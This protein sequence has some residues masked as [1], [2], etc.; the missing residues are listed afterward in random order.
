M[1]SIKDVHD[2]EPKLP[3]WSRKSLFVKSKPSEEWHQQIDFT[4]G[5]HRPSEQKF[6]WDLVKRHTDYYIKKKGKITRAEI[7][8]KLAS[9]IEQHEA[10]DV[11]ISA[12]AHAMSPKAVR[13]IL[14][15]ELNVAPTTFF[16]LEM[17][18]QSLIAANHCSPTSVTELEARWARELLPYA[19]HGTSAAG[20]Y[21]EGICAMLRTTDTPNMNALSD[22]SILARRAF[23]TFATQLEGMRLRCQ[24][25]SA[26][27]AAA[28]MTKMAQST[29]AVTPHGN[30]MSEHLMDIQFPVWRIW[31]RW[32]PDTSFIARLE[33]VDAMKKAVLVDMMALEGPDFINGTQKTLK[34]GLIK[35]YTAGKPLVRFRSLVLEVEQGTRE[36]LRDILHKTRALLHRALS[37][38]DGL[39]K[40]F[41][42]LAI[43]KPITREGLQLLEAVGK[44]QDTP[45]FPV[46]NATL[47]IYTA[48]N[49]IGGGHITALKHLICA[50]DDVRGEELR[51]VMLRPWLV[52]GIEKCIK[53][54]QAA[55]RMHINTGITWTHL[56]LEFHAFLSIVKGSQNC[57]LLLDLEIQRQ[58]SALPPLETM[59]TLL[60]IYAA[61]ADEKIKDDSS[62]TDVLKIAIAA[63]FID[64]LLEQGTLSHDLRDIVE[65]IIHVWNETTTKAN[66]NLERRSLAL[67]SSRYAGA[68]FRLRIH[69]FNQI[70][71]LS[72]DC[73]TGLLPLLQKFAEYPELSSMRFTKLLVNANDD[74][75][76]CWKGI[77]HKLICSLKPTAIIDYMLEH[78]KVHQFFDFVLDLKSLF[79]DFAGKSTEEL[80]VILR[81]QLRQWMQEIL[82]F[83]PAMMRLEHALGDYS[84][85]VGVILVGSEGLWAEYLVT[86]L[87]GLTNANEQPAELLM[88]KAIGKLSKEGNNAAVIAG[89]I[90]E[91][92]G[93]T[94]EG[95]VACEHIWHSKHG[96]DITP[97][98]EK[99]PL[100]KRSGLT[101]WKPELAKENIVPDPV[102]E[103]MI[104]GWLQD[105]DMLDT[106][107]AAMTALA[108]LL[109]LETY[110]FGIPKEK[111][112]EATN[113][114]EDQEAKMIEEAQRLESLTK[115]LRAK[116]RNPRVQ[117]TPQKQ[118]GSGFQY[119]TSRAK[120][121]RIN[122]ADYDLVP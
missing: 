113:Y 95:L 26:Y 94:P 32:K 119:K 50:I 118:G 57:L 10:R 90:C 7:D 64:R 70:V 91:L 102:V 21:L 15:V 104:A 108:S 27:N 17:Y 112:A 8:V 71:H 100:S 11:A 99:L 37:G 48:R 83:Q 62:S 77:L 84:P 76:L 42:K 4:A 2:R 114:F 107:K 66:V 121:S 74:F 16:G 1:S 79:T 101:D 56:V 22:F 18:L 85:A 78:L 65:S 43:T 58:L 44:F 81:P 54:C 111:L 6:Q 28:W 19:E 5:G 117:D 120:T 103:I 38:G 25:I 105:D 24:W 93:V 115:A 20:R 98:V 39:F 97:R 68:D 31:A 53:Q 89:F 41:V 34:D 109:K 96:A 87:E 86:I 61:V 116:V 12:C 92:L 110:F 80:P 13:A 122:F 35:Q 14:N 23:N 73:V 51:K 88:Q 3:S 9:L 45:T 36:E 72:S 82:P 33:S 106:D 47:E 55:V 46:Y 69:C 30:L 67:L 59:E 63:W 49:N 40:S 60:E 52:Q 29:P 75:A